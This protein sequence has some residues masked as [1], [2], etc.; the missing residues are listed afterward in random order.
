MALQGDLASFALPDVLRLLAGTAKSGRLAVTGSPHTG[1]VWFRDGAIAGGSVTSR[2]SASSAAEIVYELLQFDAG[3][4]LFDDDDL[5]SADADTADVDAALA[6]AEALHTEWQDVTRVVPSLDH[7]VTM[8]PELATGE[9]TIDGDQ[10]RLLAVLAGGAPVHTVARQFA[11]SDLAASKRVKDMVEGG[12]VLISEPRAGAPADGWTEHRG[13]EVLPDES[14]AVDELVDPEPVDD[15]DFVRLTADEGPV[16]LETSEDALL[17]EPLPGAGTAFSADGDG[18]VDA[19]AFTHADA[20]GEDL[21]T[22]DHD[23]DPSYEPHAGIIDPFG[24]AP[25]AEAPTVEAPAPSTD[26]AVAW[27][28]L[29]K[30]TGADDEIGTSEEAFRAVGWDENPPVDHLEGTKGDDADRSSLL[31]FLSSVKP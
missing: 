18:A 21:A 10:W 11:E 1:E 27:D 22:V 30:S 31:K 24:D 3:S 12:L 23:L 16:V 28:A 4:F 25:V 14:P 20:A 26:P 6:E 2:E 17:P 8:A 7:W 29:A 5:P 15:H 13:D 19:P 9:V